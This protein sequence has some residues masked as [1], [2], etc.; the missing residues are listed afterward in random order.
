MTEISKTPKESAPRVHTHRDLP[1][2]QDDILDPE[3]ILRDD[4]E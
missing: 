4:G 3:D 1:D 2:I